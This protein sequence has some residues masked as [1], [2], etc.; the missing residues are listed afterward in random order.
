M[1]SAKVRAEL[2]SGL[3]PPAKALK[4]H[5]S[6]E[7]FVVRPVIEVATHLRLKGGA[8]LPQQVLT[9]LLNL[10]QLCS[11]PALGE[12]ETKPLVAELLLALRLLGNR[13]FTS[14]LAELIIALLCIFASCSNAKSTQAGLAGSIAEAHSATEASS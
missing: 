12:I 9:T 13:D 4:G 5:V 8:A 2:V 14:C 11:R 7:N 10:L 3:T 1:P 6:G